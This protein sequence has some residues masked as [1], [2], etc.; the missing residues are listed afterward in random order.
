MI[1][2]NLPT[3]NL[4]KFM[5]IAGLVLFIFGAYTCFSNIRQIETAVW[6]QE[7]AAQMIEREQEWML[8]RLAEINAEVDAAGSNDIAG[9]DGQIAELEEIQERLK[10][11]NS[12]LGEHHESLLNLEYENKW[13]FVIQFGGLICA[14]VGAWLSW[15]GFRLW[16]L[17][18]QVFQDAAL[19]KAAEASE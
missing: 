12:S 14:T 17:R 6:Q 8:S 18:V 7:V 15:F 16:Y 2:S 3:D 19:R 9:R 4:Y 1:S 5:A 10:E 11:Q 13:S